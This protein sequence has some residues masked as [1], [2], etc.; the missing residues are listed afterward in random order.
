MKIDLHSHTHYSDGH[1]SPEELITRAHTM[2]VN[3]LAITDH[4]TV[5][6]ISQAI[7]YQL[8]K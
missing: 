4:D 1:L 7:E 3:V 6:G 2:Q 8:I 5:K